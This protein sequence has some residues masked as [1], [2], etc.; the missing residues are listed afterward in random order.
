[1]RHDASGTPT[2][3]RDGDDGQRYA[4]I[5]NQRVEVLDPVRKLRLLAVLFGLAIVAASAVGA[6]ASTSIAGGNATR[7]NAATLAEMD[8]RTKSR[9]QSELNLRR[10]LEQYRRDMC[11]VV[12]DHPRTA[13]MVEIINRYRCDVGYAPEVEPDWSAPPTPLP[14]GTMRATVP[15]PP[16]SPRPPVPAPG[17]S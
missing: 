5:T 12:N 10:A 4:L 16:H 8:R 14:R 11:A 13:A 2:G 7:S 1:M 9:L 3:Q 17:A 6:Y 15:E